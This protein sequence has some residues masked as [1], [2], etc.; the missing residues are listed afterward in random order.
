MTNQGIK[1]S[2]SH[3]KEELEAIVLPKL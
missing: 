2:N 3:S 1:A